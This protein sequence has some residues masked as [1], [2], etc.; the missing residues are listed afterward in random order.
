MTRG[1]LLKILC[2]QLQFLFLSVFL[3]YFVLW[4]GSKALGR[5]C[6]CFLPPVTSCFSFL[7]TGWTLV[8]F[9]MGCYWMGRLIMPL[10]CRARMSGGV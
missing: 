5:P 4:A 2:L 8:L 9:L 6:S 7:P 10:C 3:A 1:V